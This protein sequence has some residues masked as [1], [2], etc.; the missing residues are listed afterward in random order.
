MEIETIIK[1]SNEEELTKLGFDDSRSALASLKIIFS[2]LADLTNSITEK[3]LKSANPVLSLT[4][5][6][7]LMESAAGEETFKKI[8]GDEKNLS[9]IITL[10]G[11][12][13]YLTN[14]LIRY[15]G[16]FEEFFAGNYLSTS[17]DTA[18]FYSQ[19]KNIIK[20]ADGEEVEKEEIEKILRV[21]RN[22]EY[23]R[24]GLRD[25][26]AAADVAETTRE[27]SDL[28]SAT[29]QIAFEHSYNA[30]TGRYGEPYFEDFDGKIK[31]AE[32]VV[33][34]MGKLGGRE[35]NFSSDIDIIY[36][37]S[38]ANGETEGIT[39]D[40]EVVIERS[41]IDLHSF[42][43]KLS[44]KISSLI[45]TITDDG[46]V[47][48]VDLELRPDGRAGAIATSLSGAENYYEGF[49]QS[50]ERGAMI[51]ARPVAGSGNF[52]SNLGREFLE[53][54]KP[55]VY[56]R[57]LDFGS[58]EEIRLMKEKID[59]ELV[60]TK[61]DNIN[62]KLG[63]GGIREIE[64][65]CQALQLIRGGKNK[66]VR[67]PS[68]LLAIEKLAANNLISEKE[69]IAL[70]SGYI[71]LRNLEHRIQI[72]DGLQTQI[73]PGKSKDLT[74]LAITMGLGG[75]KTEN[76][77]EKLLEK[78]KEVTAEV[79]AIYKTLFY[80]S[81]K[82]SDGENKDIALILSGSMNDKEAEEKLLNLG[83]IETKEALNKIKLLSTGSSINNSFRYLPQKAKQLFEKLM[84]SLLTTIT[85]APDPD[86]ALA[87]SLN[88]LI[89]L[90]GR[91]SFYSML[92]E[93]PPLVELL[94]KVFSSSNFLARTLTETPGGLDLLLSGDVTRI[95]KTKEEILEDLNPSNIGNLD[96]EDS[97]RLIRRQK[98]L[99]TFRIGIGNISGALTNA[100]VST[101]FTFLS[102]ACLET[103]LKIAAR[104]LHTRYG[105]PKD[106][107]ALSII[108]L[109][110]LGGREVIYG[111]DLDIIFIYSNNKDN[112]NKETTGPKKISNNE[113]FIKLA[114]RVISV[115]SLKTSDGMAFEIDTE[116]RPSGN[117]GTLVITSN[118]LLDYYK[119]KAVGWEKQAFTKARP[120]AGKVPSVTKVIEEIK[121]FIYLTPPTGEELTEQLAIREKMELELAKET[122]DKIN[123]KTGKGGLVDIE[124]LAQTLQLKF[125]KTNPEV[126]STETLEALQA[127]ASSGFLTTKEL[128]MLTNAYNLYR[129]IEIK[130][131]I[132]DD[133]GISL[134]E[135]SSKD[136]ITLT[137]KL[138]KR[139]TSEEFFLQLKETKEKIRE[140]Y[141]KK[142][143]PP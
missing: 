114:Q 92:I 24:I 56:R 103:S 101:Q 119:N 48:R 36:V 132:I 102:E 38:S 26:T 112:N 4:G 86:K 84:P 70:R 100:E 50:W 58:I 120:V 39:D 47:F 77:A 107:S 127:L 88:F 11:A 68:T 3:S 95:K 17:K 59:I 96:Y 19:L 25:L 43:V 66:D 139:K 6:C 134:I 105:A 137:K 49:G 74:S 20:E 110:K 15:K 117:A 57:Y 9:A 109:G 111:S 133:K 122:K 104:E 5:F 81:E 45:N 37:Y 129:D 78:Y 44:E 14:Y 143:T 12:S 42:F 85:G 73:I 121:N 136:I 64:F 61:P 138:D 16:F 40:K 131:R 28:A 52:G 35:L 89:A 46:F 22:K 29:L 27:L 118:A 34:G 126:I 60:R 99:E 54:I 123:I 31:K 30:L 94:V 128:T 41:K 79:F 82:L 98:H 13:P 87:N 63:T 140:L 55:F 141:F 130:L 23:L 90:S 7:Q 67:T 10:T 75:E 2:N 76:L 116:L 91:A 93:N 142:V 1:N 124:F 108:G 97:L 65:F 33:I 18:S 53:M 8:I 72:K 62:V 80:S 69:K 113:Y 71:F 106:N 115:L 125:G 83:F 32:F 51:K 21:F 135:K